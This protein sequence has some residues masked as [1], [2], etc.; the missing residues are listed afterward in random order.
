[1]ALTLLAAVAVLT[2]AVTRRPME[3]LVVGAVL[4]LLV[5]A[6][7]HAGRFIELEI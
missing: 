2:A 6:A 4:T 3:V 7:A 5:L 1:M